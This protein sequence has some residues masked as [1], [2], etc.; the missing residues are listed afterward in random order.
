MEAYRVG[1][2]VEFVEGPY[3][4]YRGTILEVR[5]DG[6]TGKCFVAVTTP[7]GTENDWYPQTYFVKV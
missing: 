4:T 1:D 7:T 3:S 2:N 6:D 5:N